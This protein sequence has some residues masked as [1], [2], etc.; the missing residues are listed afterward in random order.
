VA[1]VLA[2]LFHL[3][4]IGP[5]PVT[6]D[7]C[8]N[9]SGG[10]GCIIDH[11][12][13]VKSLTTLN[14]GKLTF[15]G[16]NFDQKFYLN[17]SIVEIDK[18]FKTLRVPFDQ[19]IKLKITQEGRQSFVANFSLSENNKDMTIQI[20]DM[21]KEEMG[22]IVVGRG[23]FSNTELMIEIEGDS[24]KYQLPLSKPLRVPA[25]T[26]DAILVDKTFDTQKKI[27]IVVPP[28]QRAKINR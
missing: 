22:E 24:T 25:G 28:D 17:G 21:P 4:Y 6:D 18:T 1:S 9:G 10:T 16:T 11:K 20:P 12:G 5:K 19:N 26:Y 14:E 2:I 15:K 7:P 3:G 13:Q 8:A 23:D 27:K